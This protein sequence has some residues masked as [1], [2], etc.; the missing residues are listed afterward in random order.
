M[1]AIP[2]SH[3]A[4]PRFVAFFIS[5][6]FHFGPWEYKNMLCAFVFGCRLNDLVVGTGPTAVSESPF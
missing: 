3:F 2:R 1:V 6:H 4:Q 5:T